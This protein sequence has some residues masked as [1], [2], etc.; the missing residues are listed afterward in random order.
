MELYIWHMREALLV[1]QIGSET[2]LLLFSF[3]FDNESF[4]SEPLFI[5]MGS[6]PL[7]VSLIVFDVAIHIL[8][9]NS[10]CGFSLLGF[11]T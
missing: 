11:S 10:H 9:A 8:V 3:I 7:V 1:V 6:E 2:P 4:C 5:F